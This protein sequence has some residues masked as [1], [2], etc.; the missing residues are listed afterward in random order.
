MMN[1]LWRVFLPLAMFEDDPNNPNIQV[2]IEQ[3]KLKFG[4]LRFYHYTCGLADAQEKEINTWI[5]ECEGE[6]AKLDPFYGI[7]Y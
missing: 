4:S 1:W 3:I 5:E 6:L 2:V 7:P